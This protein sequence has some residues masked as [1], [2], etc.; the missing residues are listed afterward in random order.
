LRLPWAIILTNRYVIGKT[1]LTGK[2]DFT[3][4]W[5]TNEMREFDV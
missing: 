4:K 5:A 2:F 1:G 3:L